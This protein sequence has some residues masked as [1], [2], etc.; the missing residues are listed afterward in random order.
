MTVAALRGPAELLMSFDTYQGSWTDLGTQ[1]RHTGADLRAGADAAARWLRQ[2]GIESGDRVILS[3]SNS[4]AFLCALIALLTLDASP[5]LLHTET[6]PREL[7][8]IAERAGARAVLSQKVAPALFGE[9]GVRA[10]RAEVTPWLVF[11]AAGLDTEPQ[12]RDLRGVVLHSTSGTTGRPKLAVRTAASVLA[13]AANYLATLDL[14]HTDVILGVAPLTHVYAFGMCVAT[15]LLS[16]MDV[17]VTDKFNPRI[18]ADAIAECGVSVLP[19]VPGMLDA[20]LS[21][22]ALPACAPRLTFTAGAPLPYPLASRYF[23]QTGR[24]PLPL[25]GTT[26]TGLIS[27]ARDQEQA[28]LPDAVGIAAE[29]VVVR[30]APAMRSHIH[31]TVMVRSA[32]L[33]AGYLEHGRLD[34]STFENGWYR[35][36]DL[37]EPGPRG[38]LRLRGREHDIVNVGGLKVVPAEVEGVINDLA[39]VH[40]VKVYGRTLPGGDEQVNAAVVAD[41]RVTEGDIARHCRAHLVYYKRPAVMHLLEELPTTPSGKVLVKELP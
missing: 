24:W 7:L 29:G 26:E 19:A 9:V 41:A 23:E 6:P 21:T 18:V 28:A 30:Q 2:W 35:T 17:V 20:L 37:V 5:L 22:H 27:V 3:A 31:D 12:Y 40:A 10:D 15:P 4:P 25:Y 13:D 8:R 34:A 33:M 14:D 36:G 16:G 39:G 38:T 32:S 11:T 1:Q